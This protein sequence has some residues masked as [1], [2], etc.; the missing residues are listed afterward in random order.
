MRSAGQLSIVGGAAHGRAK[1]SSEPADANALRSFAPAISMMQ[2]A[3]PG[4]GDHGR[5]QRRLAFHGP[6]IRRVLMEEIVNPV[7]VMVVH[8]IANEPPEMLFVHRDD[9]VEKLSAAASYPAFRDSVLPSGKAAWFQSAG[10]F[11]TLR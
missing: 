10:V 6:P 1:N 8:L 5:S 4:T 3:E 7:V 9:M 11:N 2:A